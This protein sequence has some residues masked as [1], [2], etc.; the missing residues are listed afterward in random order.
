MQPYRLT[1]ELDSENNRIKNNEHFNFPIGAEVLI[2]VVVLINGQQVPVTSSTWW[3]WGSQIDLYSIVQNPNEGGANIIP[4]PVMNQ[5]GYGGDPAVIT[6][7]WIEEG[8]F[9]ISAT[10]MAGGRVYQVAGTVTIAA[11]HINCEAAQMFGQFNTDNDEFFATFIPTFTASGVDLLQGSR[12]GFL[13]VLQGIRLRIPQNSQQYPTQE[14]GSSMIFLDASEEAL[15]QNNF[16]YE[17]FLLNLNSTT[18][19]TH[20][21]PSLIAERTDADI[22]YRSYVVEGDQFTTYVAFKAALQPGIINSYVV[23]KDSWS[24]EISATIN[25]D[26]NNEGWNFEC[27]PTGNVTIPPTTATWNLPLWTNNSPA[28]NIW[29]NTASYSL[30]FA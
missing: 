29:T 6:V 8:T 19:A 22:D 2:E 24:W 17:D 5:G 25:W 13:Q 7:A 28:L 15:Q 3:L 10:G 11:P 18:Y 4:P 21:I 27:D 16:F 30:K 14:T 12:I 20:D 26:D 23:V 1:F 9:G